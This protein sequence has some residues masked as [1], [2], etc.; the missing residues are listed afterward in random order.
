MVVSP[1]HVV[2]ITSEEEK[3]NCCVDGPLVAY[4]IHTQQEAHH[5]SHNP[6]NMRDVFASELQNWKEQSRMVRNAK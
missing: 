2:A 5:T 6:A 1:K 3:R 4:L